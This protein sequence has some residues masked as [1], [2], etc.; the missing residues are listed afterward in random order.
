[1]IIAGIDYSTTSPAICIYDTKDA[2]HISNLKFF[3]ATKKKSE[4]STKQFQHHL[5]D[6]K[7]VGMERYMEL[8]KWTMETL[9]ENKVEKV[10]M[11]GYSM[12]S[13]GKVFNI[14]E[15]TGLVKMGMTQYGIKYDLPSPSQIKKYA[16]GKGSHTKKFETSCTLFKNHS[17]N[18][19]YEHFE[20][21]TDMSLKDALGTEQESPLA[22]LVDSYF[23]CKFGAF[24]DTTY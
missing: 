10:Y 7:L 3:F 11:E 12:S 15:C 9:L 24:S 13:K 19:M 23:I 8:F 22:D 20:K 5:W 6:N 2:W 16:T 1:M 21:D 14:A 17:K 4:N 18:V